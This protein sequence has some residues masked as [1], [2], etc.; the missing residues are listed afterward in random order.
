MSNHIPTT[1]EMPASAV[2]I[3]IAESTGRKSAA[4]KSRKPTAKPKVKT[5]VQSKPKA[6]RADTVMPP[7]R[8]ADELVVFA[9]RLSAEERDLIHQASGPAKASRF[10]RAV[11]L[12]AARGDVKALQ[13]ILLEVQR[14]AAG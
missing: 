14:E 8:A 7:A 13:S 2:E 4:T 10:V 11:S 5:P 9:F 6:A 12:A 3:A 1:A